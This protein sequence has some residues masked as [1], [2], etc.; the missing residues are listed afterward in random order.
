MTINE[1]RACIY[2]AMQARGMK[3]PKEIARE[4][5][6]SEHA[7][8]QFMSSMAQPKA[9]FFLTVCGW[10]GYGLARADS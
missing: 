2:R 3:Y 5:G 4:I 10:L 7:M 8:T 1:A 9:Q 6:V